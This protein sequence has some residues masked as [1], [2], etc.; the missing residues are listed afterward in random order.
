[1]TF[2]ITLLIVIITCIVSYMGFT[3]QIMFNRYSHQPFM[4]NKYKQYYRLLTSGFLHVDFTHLILNMFVFWQFGSIVEAKFVGHFGFLNGEL[5]Y[6][7]FYLSALVISDIPTMLRFKDYS[8]YNAVG[9]SG[10]VSAILF[11]FIIFQPWAML[12][13]FLIIPIPA[14]IAGVLYLAYEQ[15]AGQRGRD[16]IGHDAHIMGAVFG[17]LFIFI[18]WSGS[19]T[20][21]IYSVLHESPFWH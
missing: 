20:D 5:L 18:F 8:G 6:L 17:M 9:A 3:D 7:F 2:S 10:A 12:A 15:W 19:F 14:V 4:E 1:M 13:L 21:F 11:A 16:N